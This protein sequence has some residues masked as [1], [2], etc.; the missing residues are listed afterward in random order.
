MLLIS[1]PGGSRCALLAGMLCLSKD[2]GDIWWWSVVLLTQEAM[3]EMLMLNNTLAEAAIT[4]FLPKQQKTKCGQV[5]HVQLFILVSLGLFPFYNSNRIIHKFVA[6]FCWTFSSIW[7]RCAH[8]NGRGVG[9][10][11]AST[12]VHA[13][14]TIHSN[15][16]LQSGVAGC[17][18]GGEMNPHYSQYITIKWIF[19]ESVT[20]SQAAGREYIKC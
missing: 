15:K 11:A 10:Q 9:I 3:K 4:F 17:V 12:I 2:C 18:F 20:S 1:H 16:L 8:D 7:K 14:F 6:H 13:T 5:L 19:K